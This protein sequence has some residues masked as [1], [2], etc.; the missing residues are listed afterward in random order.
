MRWDIKKRVNRSCEMETVAK[1]GEALVYQDKEI[2][3]SD[4]GWCFENEILALK[5]DTAFQC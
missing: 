1:F 4:R 3:L 2:L 5:E